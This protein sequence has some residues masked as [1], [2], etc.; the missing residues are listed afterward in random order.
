MDEVLKIVRDEQ[1][2]REIKSRKIEKER[3]EKEN[4]EKAQSEER[5]RVNKEILD[6]LGIAELFNEVIDRGLLKMIDTRV[7]T[8]VPIY[9]NTIFGKVIDHMEWETKSEY[10]PARIEYGHENNSISLCFNSWSTEN[11]CGDTDGSG[12]ETI[13]AV[14]TPLKTVSLEVVN[15]D[16][17]KVDG[18][19]LNRENLGQIIGAEVAKHISF[20]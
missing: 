12:Y 19:P 18:V 9:K 17:R 1:F 4:R 6:N 3:I 7:S 11:S 5:S 10:E 20:N 16:E 13:T 14:V 8:N 2:N 15:Y